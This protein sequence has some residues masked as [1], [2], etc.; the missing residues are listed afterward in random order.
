VRYQGRRLAG[1]TGSMPGFLAVTLVDP[2]AQTGALALVNSTSGVGITQLCLD[3]ITI[4]DER[5]PR[6]PDEWRPSAVDPALLALTG[7]WHWGPT[8]YH[9][10]IQGDGLLLL[11]PV[12][13]A[14][15]GSRFRPIGEDTYLGLDGYYSGETLKVGRDAEGAANHLDLATFVFTRTPYDPAAPVPGGVDGWR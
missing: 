6:L 13:G 3:L 10:R 11:A 1:H 9:L 15:R 8:P 7:L 14:G 5:E 4:T 12:E 2:A